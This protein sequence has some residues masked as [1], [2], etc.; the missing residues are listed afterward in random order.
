M[1]KISTVATQQNRDF[2]EQ[3]LTIGLDLG[4]RAGIAF[5]DEAGEVVLEQRLGTTPKAMR[6]VF[7]DPY[8]RT[9]LVRGSA[10]HSGA[11]WSGQRSAALGFE[12]GGAWRQEWEETS[13]DRDRTKAGGVAASLVGERRGLRT[14][15]QQPSDAIAGSRIV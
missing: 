9:L 8:L 14:T 3:K 4:D 7:G 5:L 6:E 11:V 13:G 15:A 2:R 10:P 12:A 1:K